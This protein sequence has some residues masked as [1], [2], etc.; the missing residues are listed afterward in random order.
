MK[1]ILVFLN[2]QTMPYRGKLEHS[3]LS[4]ENI[5]KNKCKKSV[6]FKNKKQRTGD[7]KI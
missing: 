1:V 7:L 2:P 5:C 6:K 3:Q 4:M